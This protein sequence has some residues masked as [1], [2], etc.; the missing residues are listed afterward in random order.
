MSDSVAPNPDNG[1]SHSNETKTV[2]Q[3]WTE[4]LIDPARYM[5]LLI[6]LPTIPTEVVGSSNRPANQ[7]PNI[8]RKVRPVRMTTRNLAHRKQGVRR[9]FAPKSKR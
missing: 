2:N 8:R 7:M 1:R 4:Y 5:A 6:S 3:A 9:N